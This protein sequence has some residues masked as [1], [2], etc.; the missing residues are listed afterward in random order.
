MICWKTNKE[1]NLLTNAMVDGAI[2]GTINGILARYLV[3]ILWEIQS[4]DKKK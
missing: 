3:D 1:S 4:E 2:A